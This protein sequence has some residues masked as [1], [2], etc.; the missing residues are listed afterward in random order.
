[1]KYFKYKSKIGVQKRKW[2]ISL[3]FTESLFVFCI[4][5]DLIYSS[6]DIY[7]YSLYFGSFLNL[8]LILFFYS[9]M[10]RQIYLTQKQILICLP[11]RSISIKRD[12]I[13]QA[14]E[15]SYFGQEQFLNH[16]SYLRKRE[17]RSGIIK[18]VNDSQRVV[19][20]RTSDFNYLFS[21]D[22]PAS[23]ISKLTE[24]N[25]SKNVI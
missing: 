23:F 12:E 15:L 16:T 22:N 21:L 11:F 20:V 9:N 19:C 3:I 5:Y 18:Y 13:K 2:I 14:F 6:S 4:C 7:T 1:M 24:D 8:L 10:V 17:D 25:I